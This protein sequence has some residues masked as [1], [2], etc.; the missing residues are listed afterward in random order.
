MTA[1]NMCSTFRGFWCSPPLKMD[2]ET[3]RFTAES[4]KRLLMLETNASI[5]GIATASQYTLML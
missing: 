1:T 4:Q 3:R 5:Y 2:D